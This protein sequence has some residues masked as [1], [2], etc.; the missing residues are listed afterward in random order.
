MFPV[1]VNAAPKESLL[2]VPGLGG[3]SVDRILRSRRLH[4]LGLTHLQTLRVKL[5]VARPFIV[6]A[7]WWPRRTARPM[8]DSEPARQPLLWS[9]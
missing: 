5:A 3:R 9:A 1:D 4:R 7:D 6:A 2:R 8:R